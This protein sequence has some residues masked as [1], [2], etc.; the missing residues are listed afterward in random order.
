MILMSSGAGAAV[1]LGLE[2]CAV[3]VGCVWDAAAPHI[4][5]LKTVHLL[6]S[7]CRVCLSYL[8]SKCLSLWAGELV[9]G[10]YKFS[11]STFRSGVKILQG[12][13]NMQTCWNAKL[14]VSILAQAFRACTQNTPP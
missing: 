6:V 14:S 7:Y 2:L 1:H 9:W 8:E 13:P 4:F 10:N 5:V 3:S 11:L 12:T